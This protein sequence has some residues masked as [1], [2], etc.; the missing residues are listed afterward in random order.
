MFQLIY[1]KF[2]RFLSKERPTGFIIDIKHI[3]I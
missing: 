2:A 3:N 1:E